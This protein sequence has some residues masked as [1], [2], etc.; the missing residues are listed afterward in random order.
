[1][2]LLSFL[3]GPGNP[4]RRWV[5][6]PALRLEFDLSASALNGVRVGGSLEA[7]AA[8]GPVES[9][10]ELRF[11]RYCYYSQ[12]LALRAEAA[13]RLWGFEL[14]LDDRACPAYVAYAGSF[15]HAGQPIPLAAMAEGHVLAVFGPPYWRDAS[16]EEEVIL[17]YEWPDVEWQM[18]FAADGGR[19]RVLTVTAE[20]VMADPEQRGFYGV[21]AP[22]PHSSLNSPPPVGSE[23]A[24][25]FPGKR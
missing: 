11:E 10:Y 23:A 24:G 22:W 3:F 19:L 7:L 20:R 13:G 6:D 1:M 14:F 25:G 4:T 12:G 21:T 5:R 8:L 2:G 15:R 18:E 9:A 17:F 16:D